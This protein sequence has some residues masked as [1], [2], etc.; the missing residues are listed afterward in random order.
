MTSPVNV[1]FQRRAVVAEAESWLWTPFHWYAA[2]KGPGGGCD[3]GS[4]LKACYEKAGI[5]VD[6]PEYGT[7]FFLHGTE[8]VY[9]KALGRYCYACHPFEA[10]G[11]TK[12]P[13]PAHRNPYRF[14]LEC[15]ECNRMPT[16]PFPAECK[17]CGLES[18]Q[19][20][21]SYPATPRNG[22]I[23]TFKMGKA[24]GHAG[25]IVSWPLII[26]SCARDG[27]VSKVHADSHPELNFRDRLFFSLKIWHPDPSR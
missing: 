20:L 8:E 2:T 12:M 24:Y 22:D 19:H 11:W 18:G 23:V 27:F 10:K 9:L 1:E 25:V 3:C 16:E 26:H 21:Q 6:L 13:C 14:Q 17:V 15:V 7:Q 5:A 4:L